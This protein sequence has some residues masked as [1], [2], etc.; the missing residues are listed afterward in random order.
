MFIKTT[1]TGAAFIICS[2]CGSGIIAREYA[3][4]LGYHGFKYCPYCGA[5]SGISNET[6]EAFK[7][8]CL[9]DEV[10]E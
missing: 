4:A 7:E 9:M 5:E 6:G 3:Q 10:E 1:D 8:W 2:E